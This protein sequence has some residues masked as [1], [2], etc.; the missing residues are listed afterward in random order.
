MA[1]ILPSFYYNRLTV[2]E[3]SRTVLGWDGPPAA[4]SSSSASC[5]ASSASSSC[6]TSSASRSSSASTQGSAG[7]G[8]L[9]GLLTLLDGAGGVGDAFS[10]SIGSKKYSCSVEED[11]GA[12]DLSFLSGC[13]SQ[14]T[15]FDLESGRLGFKSSQYQGAQEMQEQQP[16][17][18]VMLGLM[19]AGTVQFVLSLA[20]LV[21]YFFKKEND[22]GTRGPKLTDPTATGI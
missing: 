15:D 20:L 4:A 6:S 21:R 17:S 7:C 12:V 2:N 3:I 18:T 8:Q 5:S 9:D 10:W 13:S 11:S 1:V 16:I 19:L 14:N 22:V